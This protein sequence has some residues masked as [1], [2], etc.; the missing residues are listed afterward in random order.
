M[1]TIEPPFPVE[2]PSQAVSKAVRPLHILLERKYFLDDLYEGIFVNK[3]LLGGSAM[4]AWFDTNIVDGIANG[5]A[6]TFRFGGSSLRLLQTGQVQV[7]GA[8]AFAGLLL[9]GGLV[10]LLNPL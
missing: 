4:L 2:S 9:A 5:V 8:I 6:G 10:F 3:L 7:Y 1:P